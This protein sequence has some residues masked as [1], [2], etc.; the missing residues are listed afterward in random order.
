MGEVYINS[1]EDRELTLFYVMEN[2]IFVLGLSCVLDEISFDVN[3]QMETDCEVVF[4]SRGAS[5]RLYDNNAAVK[6]IVAH[7]IAARLSLALK[8]LGK[9]AFSSVVSRIAFLLTE[10]R[11]TTGAE[12]IKITHI[13]IATQIGT[14]REV[15]T[16]LL[17]ELQDDGVLKLSRGKVAITDLPGLLKIRDT[18]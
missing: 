18:R 13:E 11:Q 10:L 16:R 6:N 17:N 8:L 1:P 7:L 9:V 3:L 12:T 4:I 2:E 15:V 14:A 5:K